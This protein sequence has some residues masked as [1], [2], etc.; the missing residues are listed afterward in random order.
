MQTDPVLIALRVAGA[1]QLAI[2]LGSLAIPAV[3]GWQADTL[4]LRPLTRQVFWI[5]GGYIW[6]THMA[7][8]SLTLL[9]P[10]LLVDGSLL[11]RLVCGFL[12]TWW[13]VRLALQFTVMDRDARPP[14]RWA[15][16]AE[17]ALVVG[18]ACLALTYLAGALR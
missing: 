8:A 10:E 12:A 14:G 18:F 2:A 5:W 4:R 16:A 7:A 1:V 9:A 13:G 6:S 11:A 15:V 17:A 3:L